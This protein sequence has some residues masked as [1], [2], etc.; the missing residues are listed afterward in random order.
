MTDFISVSG[1]YAGAFYSDK[2][3][4]NPWIVLAFKGTSPFNY[5]EWIRDATFA[6]VDAND[7]L[8][9]SCHSGYVAW[10]LSRSMKWSEA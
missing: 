3:E 10:S 4:K 9:G 1:A 7:F 2:D 6:R 5:T 8:W